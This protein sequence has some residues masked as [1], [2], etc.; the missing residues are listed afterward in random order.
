MQKQILLLAITVFTLSVIYA[1]AAETKDVKF[2]IKNSA[3]VVF[4]HETHLKRANN[5][6]KICHD[7]IY[8]LRDKRP[9]TMAE[10]EKGR[11]CGACHNGK[12]AFTAAANCDRCH[13]DMKPK[14]VTFK[15]KR[16]APAVF[17]HTFHT[18]VYSCKDCHT[19]T[20]PY[21]TVV[22]KATM[23][24]MFNGKSCGACHNGKTAFSAAGDCAKCHT[25]FKIPGLLSFNS[26]NGTIVGHFSHEFHTAAYSCNDCHTKLFPYGNG[27]RTTMKSMEGGTSCGACHD[28]NTAF[29][30]K[31]NCLKCHKKNI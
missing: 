19:K 4:S 10:M 9:Y 29:S 26:K 6:C 15:L 5:N 27:K 18:S 21:K 17:S 1:G 31:S 2:N 16:V 28:G 12:Q 30:I 20:F 8:S 23:E 13:K 25:G 22:G 24:D 3:P 14:T 7:V 11:S